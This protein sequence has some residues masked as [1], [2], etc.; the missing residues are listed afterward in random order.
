MKSTRSLRIAALIAAL[1]LLFTLTV[2]C[3]SNAVET[4]ETTAGGTSG[5]TTE[6]TPPTSW[7]GATHL[8]DKTFGEGAKTVEVEVV[9]DGYSVT[10]T[11]KTD[12]EFLG[13]ALL[14]LG[15]IDGE[16]GPYGLYIK[17]VNG[18][19]ADY[20]VDR[21]YWSISKSGDPLMTGI[22]S[23]PVE[24]GAHYELTKTKG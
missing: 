18:M 11:V 15:L 7:D 22:D 5:D 3:G 10:F 24:N 1:L 4:P 14:A 12:E 23:T 8:E 13:T 19:V 9:A 6:A 16:D 20:S 2:S 21:T 17:S